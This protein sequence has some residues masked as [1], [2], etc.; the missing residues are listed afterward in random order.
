MN[1]IM[2]ANLYSMV[3]L[4]RMS[5]ILIS[6]HYLMA[7]C[8][9]IAILN[10]TQLISQEYSHQL[11]LSSGYS[12]LKEGHNYGLLYSGG[13]IDVSY[14]FQKDRT[15]SR[16]GGSAALSFGL[17][18][19]VGIGLMVGFQPIEVYKEWRLRSGER[20][21]SY[22]GVFSAV[23]YQWQLYPLLQ[24]GHMFWLTHFN[25]GPR[26]T[27]LL[28]AD[29]MNIEISV[30]SSLIGLVSRPQPGVETY[31]YSLRFVDFIENAHERI[32]LRTATEYV[33]VQFKFDITLPYDNWPKFGYFFDYITYSKSPTFRSLSHSIGIS[34]SLKRKN[35][36]S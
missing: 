17:Y 18:D 22:L 29:K 14:S 16:H 6:R 19:G 26:Y 3:R 4:L 27:Q 13:L 35:D 8:S 7:V 11:S 15:L 30:K 20:S 2:G 21:S 28:K 36:K 33:Q 24:S 25:F 5:V 31:F 32:S 23:N 1:A 12:Q 10:S 34:W 9:F